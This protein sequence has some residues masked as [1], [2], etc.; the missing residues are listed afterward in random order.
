[1]MT[2]LREWTSSWL[3][4]QSNISRVPHD[5]DAEPDVLHNVLTSPIGGADEKSKGESN[6]RREQGP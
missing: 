3:C 5:T 6:D 2:C 1:M 4:A